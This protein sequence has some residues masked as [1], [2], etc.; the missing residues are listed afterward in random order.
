MQYRIGLINDFKNTYSFV[1]YR[2][3]G[4]AKVLQLWDACTVGSAHR[5]Y[6]LAE[7]NLWIFLNFEKVLVTTSKDEARA[8]IR[9]LL[10]NAPVDLTDLA[11]YLEV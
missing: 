9:E 6:Q 1:D 8:K 11:F 4:V 10:D 3:I 2:E 7:D 5:G